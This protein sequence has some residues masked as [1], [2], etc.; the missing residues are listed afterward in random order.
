MIP[1]TLLTNAWTGVDTLKAEL[2][3]PAVWALKSVV[4]PVKTT[5]APPEEINPLKWS[6]PR[7]GW[8]V[9]MAQGASV[10]RSLQ[11]LIDQRGGRIWRYVPN[12]EYSFMHLRDEKYR[13]NVPMTAPKWGLGPD[14]LPYYLL[15]FGSPK[16]VPW[17]VQYILNANR[18]V[19]RLDLTGGAL[20]SYIAALTSDWSNSQESARTEEVVIWSVVKSPTDITQLMRDSI[21]GQIAEHV[22]EDDE[23]TCSFL[24]GR[25][26]ATVER[27]TETLQ[28]SKPGLIVTTSHGNTPIRDPIQMDATLGGMVDQQQHILTSSAIG[29][30]TVFGAIWYAH[31]CCSA[32]ADADSFYDGLFKPGSDASLLVQEITRTGSRVAPL[33]TALLGRASPI[34]AFVGH[35]EPTFDWTLRDP[36]TQTIL[37]ENLIRAFYNKLFRGATI[38]HA[39]RDWYTQI[40]GLYAKLESARK[41]FN[42]GVDALPG[43]FSAQLAARDIQSLVILGDPT[44]SLPLLQSLRR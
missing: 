37:T 44:V 39:L 23:L 30:S 15:I 21:A 43:I 33:P 13:S 32:G 1:D 11:A 28:R 41:L 2:D 35:V 8:G 6:D 9:I 25:N 14:A 10:P 27:L 38:G 34:R 29:D 26:Q 22:S 5:L 4:E 3:N 18:C 31:A 7:V 17:R 20:E 36:V 40:G 42:R 24:D 19:G 12:W 16:E